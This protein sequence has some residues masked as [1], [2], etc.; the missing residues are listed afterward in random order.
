ME[1]NN[2]RILLCDDHALFRSGISSLLK[3]EPDIYVVGEAEN[4]EEM[5]IKYDMLKPDVLLI[6]ISMPVLSGTDAVKILKKS[7]PRAKV[8]FLSMF[9]D[10]QYVYYTLK[11][12]GNGLI[13]KNIVKGE[14]IY[15]IRSVYNGKN[16]FGPLY[17]GDKLK[18]IITRYD[19]S[20]L[21]INVEPDDELTKTEVKIVLYVGQGLS[22]TEIAE[23]MKISKRTVDFHRSNAMK[24]LGLKTLSEFIIYSSKYTGGRKI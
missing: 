15:A 5:L 1:E 19:F 7:Y 18:E 16:Y 22:S 10:D 3:D 24:K 14:L 23:K 6:D 12:G 20:N 9:F 17:D 2:I 21:H 11:V 4:G 8:L 13:E